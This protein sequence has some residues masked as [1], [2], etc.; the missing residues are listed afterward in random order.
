[1]SNLSITDDNIKS[2]LDN[3]DLNLEKEIKTIE[4]KINDNEYKY[5]T[6]EKKEIVNKI[7]MLSKIEHI[8]IFKILKKNNIKYTENSNGIFINF[9]NIN[10][11]VIKLLDNF[12]KFFYEN[13]HS[14]TEK[15]NMLKEKKDIIEN[16]YHSSSSSNSEDEELNEP[17]NNKING[18]NINLKK[19]KPIFT[20]VKAK[21]MKNYKDS[22]KKIT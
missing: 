15:E 22:S 20:G 13:K 4:S 3:E 14:L 6:L 5:T 10:N 17:T 7:K 9:I 1:M 18:R 8:E 2:T 19:N 12:I 16:N 21:I 11:N